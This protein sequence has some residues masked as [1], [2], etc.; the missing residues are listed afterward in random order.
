MIKNLN[1]TNAVTPNYN[2]NNWEFSRDNLHIN[3]LITNNDYV[4][5]YNLIG[6]F[7]VG[8]EDINLHVNICGIGDG[9]IENNENI[10]FF[11]DDENIINCTTIKVGNLENGTGPILQMSNKQLPL[12]LTANSSHVIS[13]Q[14]HNLSGFLKENTNY[15]ISLNC[16]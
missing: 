11:L 4:E 5:Q 16:I 3:L 1:W 10:S 2:I 9:K 8:E 15:Q 14:F 7:I 12:P 13:I 6:T